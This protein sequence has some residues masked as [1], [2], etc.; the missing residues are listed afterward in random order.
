VSAAGRQQE[1]PEPFVVERAAAA[2]SEQVATAVAALLS[3]LRGEPVAPSPASAVT[4]ARLLRDEHH[5]AVFVARSPGGGLAGFAG[6]TWQ[7]ALHVGGEYGLIQ[8]V[9]TAPSW[10]GRG[11]G[12]ALVEAIRTAAR[13]HG[14]DS[15]EVGLPRASYGEL[16]ATTAFYERLGFELVGARMRAP[17]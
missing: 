15:L 9:W 10:R 7:L 3:E 4:L 2:D 13:A 8:E 12:A 6:V 5:G 17:A 1:R 11:V 16:A 14:V